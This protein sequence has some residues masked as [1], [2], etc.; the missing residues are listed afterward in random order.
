MPE[1]TAAAAAAAV[2]AG[3][4]SSPV[5]QQAHHQTPSPQKGLPLAALKAAG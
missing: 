4:R 5:C 1:W 3:T 2:P